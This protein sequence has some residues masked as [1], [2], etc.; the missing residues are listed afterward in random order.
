MTDRSTALCLES[1]ES[2]PSSFGLA[3]LPL[4]A[5]PSA[6]EPMATNNFWRLALFKALLPALLSPFSSLLS[7]IFVVAMISNVSDLFFVHERGVRVS[8]VNFILVA[9]SQLYGVQT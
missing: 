7:G 4:L 1:M 6:K 3:F 8:I 9:G 5:V 2:V